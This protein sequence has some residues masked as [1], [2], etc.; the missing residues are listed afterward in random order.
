MSERLMKWY[1]VA[2]GFVTGALTLK[3][4]TFVSEAP[5]ATHHWIPGANISVSLQLTGIGLYVAAIAGC[6]GALV[7]LYSLKYMED[8]E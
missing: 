6:I 4:L 3:L 7:L 5:L 1:T 2:L 8:E